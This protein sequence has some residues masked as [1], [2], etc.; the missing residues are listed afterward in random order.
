MEDPEPPRRVE[1]VEFEPIR[2]G[3]PR[4]LHR[5]R[6][7]AGAWLVV[8]GSF[9]GFAAFSRAAPASDTVRD[10]APERAAQ[11]SV[12]VAPSS[13][14]PS[15]AASVLGADLRPDEPKTFA[16]TVT[17]TSGGLAIR[18][19]VLGRAVASVAARV[20]DVQGAAIASRSLS[21]GDPDGGIRPAHQLGF[22]VVFGLS[23]GQQASASF[24]E[25][26]GYDSS[27]AIVGSSLQSLAT[28][29]GPCGAGRPCGSS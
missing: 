1:S 10:T 6:L 15:G 4:R 21:I 27:G 28:L 14:A 18:G 3:G 20:V 11:S 17:T 12:A 25:V 22:T 8:L 13:P 5:S 9:V 19:A 29:L 16:L 23:V 24:V 26:D 2:V 7:V